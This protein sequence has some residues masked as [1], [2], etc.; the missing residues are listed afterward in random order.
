MPSYVYILAS[1]TT[2]TI[3]TGVTSNIIKRVSEHKVDVRKGFTSKY[4]VH[5]LVWYEVHEDI[6]FAIQREKCIKNW[7]R[8]WKIRLI[9]ETNP[10]WRDLFPQIAK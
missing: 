7:K 10:D 3:Y 8:A 9:E 2:G 6:E 4:G 5:D 1:K